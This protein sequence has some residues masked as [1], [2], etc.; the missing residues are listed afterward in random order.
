MKSS[1]LKPHVVHI[2]EC[3]ALGSRPGDFRVKES[4]MDSA[5]GKQLWRLEGNNVVLGHGTTVPQGDR[6]STTGSK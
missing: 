1:R 2:R 5:N 4:A 3:Q 6:K